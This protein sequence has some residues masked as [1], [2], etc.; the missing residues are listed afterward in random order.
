MPYQLR[1]APRSEKKRNAAMWRWDDYAQVGGK[2]HLE[3]PCP[4]GHGFL[5]A[6]LF[7]GPFRNHATA[8]FLHT[9]PIKSSLVAHFSCENSSPYVFLYMILAATFMVIRGQSS[10]VGINAISENVYA[11]N[12]TRRCTFRE[13]VLEKKTCFHFGVRYHRIFGAAPNLE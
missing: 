8:K 10:A 2:S 5:P 12:C 7:P 4:F 11:G 9:H 1:H 3:K 6:L 13:V